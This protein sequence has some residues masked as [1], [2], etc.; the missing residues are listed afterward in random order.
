MIPSLQSVKIVQAKK[1]IRSNAL[2]EWLNRSM[3]E[4]RDEWVD[5]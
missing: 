5:G 1:Q 3:N 4:R 2:V